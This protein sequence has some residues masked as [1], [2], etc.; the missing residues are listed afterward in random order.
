MRDRHIKIS[1]IDSLRRPILRKLNL[2][3]S[4]LN[5]AP[6]KVLNNLKP[7]CHKRWYLCAWFSLRKFGHGLITLNFKVLFLFCALFSFLFFL[8]VRSPQVWVWQLH[9]SVCFDQKFKVSSKR[10]HSNFST[11]LKNI[12]ETVIVT[13]THI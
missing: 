10:H 9:A 6:M 13:G 5:R 12:P 4:L 2:D 8:W 1:D 7:N 3:I 11:N